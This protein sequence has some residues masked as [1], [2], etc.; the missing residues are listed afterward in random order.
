MTFKTAAIATLKGLK[1]AYAKTQYVRNVIKTYIKDTE[2][3]YDPNAM[4]PYSGK[5]RAQSIKEFDESIE[6]G[7][8]LPPTK[9]FGKYIESHKS[10]ADNFTTTKIGDETLAKKLTV[11]KETPDDVKD[12]IKTTKEQIKKALALTD[13]TKAAQ[14]AFKDSMDDLKECLDDPNF[15][16]LPKGLLDYLD[17]IRDIAAGEI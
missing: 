11:T 10:S 6:L 9:G 17:W 3:Q 12:A 2:Y 13:K 8:K 16:Y 5:S 15:N 1:Y 14:K 4:K 7:K